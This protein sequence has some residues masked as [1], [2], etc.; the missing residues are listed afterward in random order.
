MKGRHLVFLAAGWLFLLAH[1][2]FGQVASQTVTLKRATL[3]SRASQVTNDVADHALRIASYILSS[4]EFQDSVRRRS[5]DYKNVCDGCG[6][7][8]GPS[9]PDLQG[10]QIVNSLLRTPSVTLTLTVKPLGKRPMLGKCFGLGSTCPNTNSILSFYQNIMCDMGNDFPFEYAY[11]VHLCHEYTHN[12]G[13][14]HTDNSQERDV[15]E[16]IGWI[17]FHYMKKWYDKG[18][19]IP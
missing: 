7:T 17:A 19:R 4:Q 3:N 13:Y 11:A 15:A 9:K 5:Y 1:A 6:P 18:T 14:C 2:A 12:V 8:N 16:S 10:S